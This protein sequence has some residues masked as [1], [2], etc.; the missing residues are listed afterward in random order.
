TSGVKELI[1]YAQL[2]QDGQA[3]QTFTIEGSDGLTAAQQGDGSIV[4]ADAN[5]ATQ[6]VIPPARVWD[7]NINPVSGDPQEG[8]ATLT[9]TDLSS[10]GWSVTIA[11]DPTWL[12]DSARVWPVTLDPTVNAGWV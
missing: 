12:A 4:F 2:P 9:L 11:A 7:S 3:S 1:Q 5:G 6:F 8:P 10:G